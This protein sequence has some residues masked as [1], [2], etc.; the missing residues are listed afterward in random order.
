MEN[1][2]VVK[3]ISHPVV[4]V[5]PNGTVAG[6]FSSIKE[7][8]VKSGRGR[9]AISLSC[10]KGSICKGFKWYYEKDF[11]KLYKE[12]RMDELKFSPDP[13]REKDSG[14]YC[15]GHKQYKRFQDWSKELQEK[16]RVISRENCLR[17]INDPDFSR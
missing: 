11:R 12:Q 10:R 17:L 8:A 4:A 7:A 1:G 6:Y 16:R 2:N 14:H 9:H 5:N 15:K 3:R 13:N